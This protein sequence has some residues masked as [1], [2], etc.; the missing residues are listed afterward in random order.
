MVPRIGN[1]AWQLRGLILLAAWAW[2][3]FGQA[4]EDIRTRDGRVHKDVVVQ[5]QTD[6]GIVLQDPNGAFVH[7]RYVDLPEN[8]KI[9]FGFTPEKEQAYWQR[10]RQQQTQQR[11]AAAAKE[12]ARLAAL[13]LEKRKEQE[14]RVRRALKGAQWCGSGCIVT[15]HGHILTSGHVVDKAQT[16]LIATVDD[17]VEAKLLGI[18]READ[19]AVL[20][21]PGDSHVPV[22]IASGSDVQ[23]GQDVM[24]IGFPMPG[25][26]GI[27]PKVSTG[28]IGSMTGLH[29][30]KREY[31]ISTPVQPG[32]SGGPLLDTC[33]NL[34]G[35]VY[36]K[37]SDMFMLKWTGQVAQ[38]VNYAVKAPYIREL[39][40]AQFKDV[41]REATAKVSTQ[42]LDS[43]DVVRKVRPAVVMIIVR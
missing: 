41:A 42:E 21:I 37:I 3:C 15:R 39:L 24:T 43:E 10:I 20:K 28:I 8:L 32:N 2:G 12:K 40:A 17:V 35:V 4:A 7:L 14:K 34:V 1:K 25:V 33:G 9:R 6:E 5:R 22:A 31:Q 11:E 27:A 26:Q 16:I 19:I 30:S 13:A 29:D 18:H 23:L 36:A 38:G